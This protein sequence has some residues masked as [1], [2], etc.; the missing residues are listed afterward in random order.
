MALNAE[1][2]YLGGGG[3][4]GSRRLGRSRFDCGVGDGERGDKGF[5]RATGFSRSAST[6]TRN[7]ILVTHET[8]SIE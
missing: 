8:S 7:L 1:C 2:D 4:V 3:G 5:V 6:T